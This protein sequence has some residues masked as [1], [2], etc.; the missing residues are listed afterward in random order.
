MKQSSMKNKNSHLLTIHFLGFSP[1]WSRTKK[2]HER[3]G[4]G[5]ALRSYTRERVAQDLQSSRSFSAKDKKWI[6]ILHRR[7]TSCTWK[8]PLG[9]CVL[10]CVC[11]ESCELCQNEGHSQGHSS[12][13]VKR[14][15][16]GIEGEGP[17]LKTSTSG[18]G[19]AWCGC[20]S[21]PGLVSVASTL[22]NIFSSVVWGCFCNKCLVLSKT[23]QNKNKPQLQ[24][25]LILFILVLSLLLCPILLP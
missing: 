24:I 2:P 17:A 22:V 16:C 14:E 4:T 10:G 21:T 13:E 25:P 8:G 12:G 9:D 23:K 3:K 18:G 6:S 15:H 11:R 19:T 5:E 7:W 1:A 20:P